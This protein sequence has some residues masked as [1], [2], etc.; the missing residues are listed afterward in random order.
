MAT[1]ESNVSQVIARLKAQ[2]ASV[3]TDLEIAIVNPVSYAA[4][5]DLGYTRE[6][7]WSELSRAQ[8]AAII[9]AMKAK[10]AGAKIGKKGAEGE[11]STKSASRATVTRFDGG[12]RII[13]AP[14]AITAKSVGPVRSIGKGILDSLPD[15]F[16]AQD[17]RNAM[18]EIAF[19]AQ[20]ILVSNTP[21]DHGVLIKGWE[22]KQL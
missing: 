20:A 18:L 9:L 8:I 17:L 14:A 5:V 21:V 2:Y 19:A 15:G 16:G 12:Y 3:T 22:I 7:R 11:N 1:T 10:D 6:V 4:A 13:V